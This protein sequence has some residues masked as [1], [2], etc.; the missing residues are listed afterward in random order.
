MLNQTKLFFFFF[1][2]FCI[3]GLIPRYRRSAEIPHRLKGLELTGEIWAVELMVGSSFTVIT[4][5]SN[6]WMTVS[7]LSRGQD[8]I[9]VLHVSVVSQAQIELL[10]LWALHFCFCEAFLLVRHLYLS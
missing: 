8:A 6:A 7:I 2:C 4:H 5:R 9:V 3:A 1:S 10:Y